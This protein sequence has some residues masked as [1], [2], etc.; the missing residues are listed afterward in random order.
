MQKENTVSLHFVKAFL[1]EISSNIVRLNH[2]GIG[3]SCKNPKDESKKYYEKIKGTNF[4]LYEEISVNKFV[5]WYFIGDLTEW[6]PP[7]FE[8]VLTK[9]PVSLLDDWNPH[10]HIDIDTNLDPSD[11]KEKVKSI[12]GTEF[13]WTL[14]IPN[15]G[16]V[17]GMKLLG[18][19]NGTKIWLGVST[20]NRDVKYHRKNLLKAISADYY[21]N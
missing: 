17:M 13:D 18:S 19:I 15:I 1:K 8:M 21:K 4:K 11:L 10:F 12:F 2:V 7:I 3:Y 14:D 6:E 20:P 9:S 16:W 5:S